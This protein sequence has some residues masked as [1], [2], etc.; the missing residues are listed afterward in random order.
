MK[1]V[2]CPVCRKPIL[3][4]DYGGEDKE[5]SYHKDCIV[6]KLTPRSLRGGGRKW[7]Q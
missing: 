5:G 1:R 2:L 4:D 7:N 3:I 6:K